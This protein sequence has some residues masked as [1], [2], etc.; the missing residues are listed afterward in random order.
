MATSTLVFNATTTLLFSGTTWDTA[1]TVTVTAVAD[2]K[3][4]SDG[5]ATLTHA[6]ANYGA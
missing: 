1:Q 5:A 4:L 2:H 6:V 3:R